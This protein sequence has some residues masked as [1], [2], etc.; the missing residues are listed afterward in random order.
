MTRSITFNDV[1]RAAILEHVLL[2]Q[3]SKKENGVYELPKQADNTYYVKFENTWRYVFFDENGYQQSGPVRPAK[4]RRLEKQARFVRKLTPTEEQTFKYKS[5]KPGSPEQAQWLQQNKLKQPSA[6]SYRDPETGETEV[7]ATKDAAEVTVSALSKQ[8]MEQ[9]A[10]AI[11]DSKGLV[12]DDEAS[13][14]NSFARIRTAREYEQIN[15]IFKKQ[16]SNGRSL[17]EYVNSFLSI[18][19]RCSIAALLY[20][21]LKPS[22]YYILR[23]LVSYADVKRVVAWI[24]RNYENSIYNSLTDASWN[25]NVYSN[26]KSTYYQ[27]MAPS[28]QDVF[29]QFNAVIQFQFPGGDIE[30]VPKELQDELLWYAAEKK[31]LSVTDRV[32]Q[33]TARWTNSGAKMVW[34]YLFDTDLYANKFAEDLAEFDVADWIAHLSA[35][36]G[37]STDIGY[38]ELMEAFRDKIYSIEGLAITFVL[39]KIPYI[40]FAVKAVFVVLAADSIYRITQG[41][42]E[43]ILWLIFDILGI[44]GAEIVSKAL[45]PIM[46]PFRRVIGFIA[47]GKTV[48]AALRAAVVKALQGASGALEKLIGINIGQII[49]E[50]IQLAKTSIVELL[51]KSGLTEAAAKIATA[52]ETLKTKIVT[53]YE[54]TIAPVFAFLKQCLEEVL[55]KQG[56]KIAISTSKGV[57]GLF[58]V[59]QMIKH[60]AEWAASQE[61]KRQI[62][63]F[64]LQHKQ[65]SEQEML[66]LFEQRFGTDFYDQI[67]YFAKAY[68]L[69]LYRLPDDPNGVY[70]P[71]IK[72][73]A[74]SDAKDE[75]GQIR[76]FENSE[77]QG[78]VRVLLYKD[79][80]QQIQVA[81]F[82]E[83]DDKGVNE[84]IYVKKSDLYQFNEKPI[85]SYA[86]AK[87]EK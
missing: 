63:L 6:F 39:D 60:A 24:N 30:K 45:K 14:V 23:N 28:V 51:E 64:E 12:W 82:K 78:Y 41:D 80:E 86:W 42:Y 53:F 8:S 20:Q 37:V 22:D 59:D 32:M 74:P 54:K 2:E 57:A 5:F 69:T 18:A 56:T 7:I 13:T 50:G 26:I 52:L 21:I 36:V 1:L 70:K 65:E 73:T 43:Y 83:L 71:Y 19:D 84:D 75:Y 48:P 67:V 72:W 85:N 35:G 17:T 58:I 25:A 68:P 87:S 34:K 27:G 49:T 61:A 40:T 55:G 15:D 62:E 47:R 66:A 38:D 10:K 81:T 4:V 11:W 76:V 31:L 46:A 79:V 44:L 3:T 16:Y 33:G 77:Q 29:D 9:I